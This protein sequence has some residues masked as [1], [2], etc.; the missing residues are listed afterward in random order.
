MNVGDVF[1]VDL[2]ARGGHAQAGRRPAI[3]AQNAEVSARLPTVLVVPLTTQQDAL[4]FPGTVLIEPDR[5]NGLRR[6][7]IILVFQLTVLDRRLVAERMGTASDVVM[8]AVW[9]ALDEITGRSRAV[10]QPR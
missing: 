3:I 1:W 7:S 9:A 5:E 2:P 4:R 8:S 6:P 10:D